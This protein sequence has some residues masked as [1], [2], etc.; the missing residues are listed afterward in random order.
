MYLITISFEEPGRVPLPKLK[1][2][3][4][5]RSQFKDHPFP[6]SARGVPDQDDR[7]L[8]DSRRADEDIRAA[9]EGEVRLIV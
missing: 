4:V 8:P 2:S 3:I 6:I 5:Q 9:A 7:R 1:K